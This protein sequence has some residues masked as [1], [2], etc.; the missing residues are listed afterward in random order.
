MARRQKQSGFTVV[1]VLLGLILI[2][3]IGF[4][5]YY[6]WHSQKKT[7]DTKNTA[8]KTSQSTLNDSS[9]QQLSE[10][11]TNPVGHFSVNYPSGWTLKQAKTVNDSVSP[12]AGATLTDPS[13][14]YH[15]SMS[16][17][18]GGKGGDCQP[19][20]SDTPFASGN[21]CAS[22]EFLSSETLPIHNVYRDV[23]VSK[24]NAFSFVNSKIVLITYHYA[25]GDGSSEYGIGVT[26]SDADYPI[27]INKPAMGFFTDYMPL[28]VEDSQKNNYPG[29]N[30]YVVSSSKDF[31][32]SSQASIIKQILRTLQ[33][34]L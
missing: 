18:N 19:K 3:I 8:D 13:G 25:N 24:T 6:V 23:Y 5:G 26:N 1:E 21:E 20:G 2:A 30:I 4:A 11:Y 32:T 14:K 34:N 16:S 12:Y 17:N 28:N 33:F 29:S 15:L 10:T 27:Q 22:M 9:A 31:L 7:D